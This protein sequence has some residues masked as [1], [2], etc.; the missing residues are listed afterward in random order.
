MREYMEK[1][2]QETIE[3]INNGIQL[4]EIYNSLL[5]D[6]QHNEAF[7]VITQAQLLIARKKLENV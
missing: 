1:K 2:I 5:T 4:S 6:L 7:H 3:K